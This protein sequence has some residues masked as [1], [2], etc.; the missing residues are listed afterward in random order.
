MADKINILTGTGRVAVTANPHEARLKLA[1]LD[2]DPAI[3][4]VLLDHSHP[5]HAYRTEERRSLQIVAAR[6]A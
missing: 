2:S 3:V 5:M 1:E 4:N 6:K